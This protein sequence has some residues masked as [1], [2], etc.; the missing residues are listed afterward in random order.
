M[1]WEK[2]ESHFRIAPAG[3]IQ[4]WT[5]FQ[6][7]SGSLKVQRS[8]AIFQNYFRVTPAGRIL[9]SVIFRIPTALARKMKERSKSAAFKC[10]ALSVSLDEG[11][12][13]FLSVLRSGR[14]VSRDGMQNRRKREFLLLFAIFHVVP[15]VTKMAVYYPGINEKSCF[16]LLKSVGVAK[17]F[18]YFFSTKWH[19]VNRNNRW[20]S[21]SAKA[22]HGTHARKKTLAGI[23]SPDTASDLEQWSSDPRALKQ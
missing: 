1:K 11:K 2:S 16:C 14:N 3:R 7:S 21:E 20:V 4:G 15:S 19:L 17:S 23:K 18:R 22:R 6:I 12:K 10:R 5:I 9:H 8:R 13:S